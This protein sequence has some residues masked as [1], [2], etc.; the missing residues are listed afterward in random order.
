MDI[1]IE[2]LICAMCGLTEDET[3]EAINENKVVDILYENFNVDIEDFENIV[4]RLIDFTPIVTS[5][6]GGRT[7]KAFVTEDDR[8]M[9]M[10]KEI[11]LDSEE[12]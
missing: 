6:L 5:S 12:N 11:K 2:E 9:I 10:R 8:R 4:N 1:E 3:E 7:F